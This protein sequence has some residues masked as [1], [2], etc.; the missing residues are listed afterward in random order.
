MKQYIVKVLFRVNGNLE[1]HST[2]LDA[3]RDVDIMIEEMNNANYDN[4]DYIG[5]YVEVLSFDEDDLPF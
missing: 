4:E 5:C 3:L 1:M 2:T